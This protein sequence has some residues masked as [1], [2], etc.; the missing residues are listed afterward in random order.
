MA[1]E[2][3][4]NEKDCENLNV[5][6]TMPKETALELWKMSL[7][8]LDSNHNL[9]P[10][11]LSK[12]ASKIATTAEILEKTLSSLASLF[13]K[14]SMSSKTQSQ[15]RS[16]FDLLGIPYAEDMAMFWANEVHTKI[17]NLFLKLLKSQYMFFV[18]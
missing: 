1:K 7:Q 12:A 5:L 18:E 9:S 2:L 4:F 15:T 3:Y 8:I 16:S 17:R 6:N 13:L 14:A 11:Q 10:K